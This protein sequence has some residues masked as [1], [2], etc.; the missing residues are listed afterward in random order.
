MSHIGCHFGP[1]KGP[2]VIAGDNALRKL[3]QFRPIQHLPK[4]GLPK[5]D[6]LQ[7][8]AL[9]RF[10]IGQQPHLFQHLD[11][12]VL[13]LVNNQNSIPALCMCTE[14]V[15]IDVID[16]LLDADITIQIWDSE[17]ITDGR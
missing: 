7:Q 14:Q 1:C 16:I 3:T 4:L 8:L 17:F 11:R 9:I 13:R 10:Q 15:V 6:D 12:E 2:E 5:Q